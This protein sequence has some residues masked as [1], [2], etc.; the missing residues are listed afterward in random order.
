MSIVAWA[1]SAHF[2]V[3]NT[4]ADFARAHERWQVDEFLT[5]VLFLSVSA[6]VVSLLQSRRHLRYRRAAERQ[7]YEAARIDGLTKLPNRQMF[8]ELAGKALG[9]AWRS[10]REC[11]ILFLDLDGFKPV[12]DTF[13][14]T[15]SAISS[16]SRSVN[17]FSEALRTALSWRGLAVTSSLSYLPTQVAMRPCWSRG[18]CSSSFNGLWLS[19]NMK[20]A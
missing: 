5:L 13:L 6:F 19:P 20:C 10:G 12:N 8:L 15:R 1:A 2:N 4:I 18:E 7:A 14:D 11:S 16:S 3:A 9:E 17:A